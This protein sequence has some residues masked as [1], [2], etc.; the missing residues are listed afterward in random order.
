MPSSVVSMRMAFIHQ[1]WNGSYISVWGPVSGPLIVLPSNQIWSS[2][3][4]CIRRRPPALTLHARSELLAHGLWQPRQHDTM[5][6][7]A[8]FS[9]LPIVRT[10]TCMHDNVL[11]ADWLLERAVE[12]NEWIFLD[13]L[14]HIAIAFRVCAPD[15]NQLMVSTQSQCAC[16]LTQS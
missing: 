3:T 5:T 16:F 10:C 4:Y 14:R 13:I 15:E 6:N 9:R 8:M 7:G 12:H 11:K 1:A 2:S